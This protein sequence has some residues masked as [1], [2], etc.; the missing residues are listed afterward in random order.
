MEEKE[1]HE[2]YYNS[3]NIKTFQSSK[4]FDRL[5]LY[6]NKA[7]KNMLFMRHSRSHTSLQGSPLSVRSATMK[8]FLNTMDSQT[9]AE[10]GMGVIDMEQQMA[11]KFV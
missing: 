10:I 8:S 9:K 5:R 1:S 11:H 4:S 2:S 3:L 6:E 7:G